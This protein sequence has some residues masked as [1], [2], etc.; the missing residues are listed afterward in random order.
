[1]E[2]K[3]ATYRDIGEGWRGLL[4]CRNQYEFGSPSSLFILLV[5]KLKGKTKGTISNSY[6]VDILLRHET[7]IRRK[8]LPHQ[9]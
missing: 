5:S 6:C 1:M 9:L 7:R 4:G 3:R 2:S 8:E